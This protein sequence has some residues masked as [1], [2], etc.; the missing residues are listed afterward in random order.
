MHSR[1]LP[2]FAARSRLVYI[3]AGRECYFDAREWKDVLSRIYSSTKEDS[4]SRIHPSPLVKS[5][6][7]DWCLHFGANVPF[8]SVAQL[9]STHARVTLLKQPLKQI[10]TRDY[11]SGR[12]CNAHASLNFNYDVARRRASEAPMK[13]RASDAAAAYGFSSLKQSRLDA[14]IKLQELKPDIAKKSRHSRILLLR[15][16]FIAIKKSRNA[17]R[18]RKRAAGYAVV[19]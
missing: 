5:Y 4:R 16:D 6:T 3:I 19:L 10:R 1:I 8:S 18:E 11:V 12:N 17:V 14:C 7:R 13:A 9:T 15:R 2:G